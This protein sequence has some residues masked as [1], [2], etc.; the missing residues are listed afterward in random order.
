MNPLQVAQ[1]S[2][3]EERCPSPEPLSHDPLKLL[4]LR[5]QNNKTPNFTILSTFCPLEG[6]CS[7]VVLGLVWSNDLESYAGGIVVAGKASHGG[8]VKDDGPD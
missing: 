1:L 4:T 8:R 3:H 7:V 2:P 6:F 5:L